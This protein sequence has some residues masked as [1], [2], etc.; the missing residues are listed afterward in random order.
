M[1]YAHILTE[2][3]TPQVVVGVVAFVVVAVAV[4]AFGDLSLALLI[5]S[6]CGLDIWWAR[7]SWVVSACVS[8]QVRIYTC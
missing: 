2:G 6:I 8:R 1:Y 3:G 4:V 7:R 5:M